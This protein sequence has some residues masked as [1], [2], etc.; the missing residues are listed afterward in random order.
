MFCREAT[1]ITSSYLDGQLDDREVRLYEE[2]IV[3]CTDCR[4]H[5]DLLKQIPMALHT[6]RMLAPKP[7]FTTLVMQRIIV[8]Q[9]F[10]DNNHSSELHYTSFS[11]NE[12]AHEDD[13][14]DELEPEESAE[15]ELESAH[16][17]P[18][19]LA[20]YAR[21]RHISRTSQIASNYVLRF[22]SV[23]AALVMMVG[24]SL[25]AFGSF[26]NTAVDAPTAAV[27]G[28]IKDFADNLRNALSSPLELAAGIAIS[29]VILVGLWYLLRTL[30]VNEEVSARAKQ[31]TEPG[32]QP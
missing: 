28:S 2:H 8:K 30:R 15:D 21:D 17:Q 20:N 19:S 5:L 13:E 27:Y 26:S 14:D 3:I 18:I 6:D 29:G 11:F 32:N 24:V 22:S 9:Q 7:E 16:P 4:D 12:S 31:N 1:L 25:Y 23:A 10:G